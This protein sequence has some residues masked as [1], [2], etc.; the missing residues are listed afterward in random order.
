MTA[1]EVFQFLHQNG[2]PPCIKQTQLI[3]CD[4]HT[5]KG[6]WSQKFVCIK[7]YSRSQIGSMWCMWVTFLST[8][9]RSSYSS[10]VRS[11]T[12]RGRSVLKRCKNGPTRWHRNRNCSSVFTR[13]WTF[14]LTNLK[15]ETRQ[16]I[17]T[18]TQLWHDI[19]VV[20]HRLWVCIRLHMEVFFALYFQFAFTDQPHVRNQL[21]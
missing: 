20:L 5:C 10:T 6:T 15:T 7:G 12:H 14:S 19:S 1:T 3:I 18:Y 2:W 17:L 9:S 16:N 21:I 4:Q 13:G 8:C 11:V